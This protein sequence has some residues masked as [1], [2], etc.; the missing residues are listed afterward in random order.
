MNKKID[1]MEYFKN[2]EILKNNIFK[3]I[4]SPPFLSVL[5]KYTKFRAACSENLKSCNQPF[6]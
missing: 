5:K 4:P 3:T 6:I 1:Y 2:I